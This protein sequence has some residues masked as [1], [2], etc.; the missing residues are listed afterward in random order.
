MVEGYMD[1]VALAQ[2]GIHNA[3]ATLGTATT[4]D[5]LSRLFRLVSRVVFCF[6]GDRAGRQ[7]PVEHWKPRC[8]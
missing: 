2:Y 8:R 6:D 4:E 1:V 7:P 3:V 5:H